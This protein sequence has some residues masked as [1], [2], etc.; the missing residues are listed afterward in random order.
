MLFLLGGVRVGQTVPPLLLDTLVSA[1]A[2]FEWTRFDP[3][4]RGN[5]AK[6]RVVADTQGS[7]G[8]KCMHGA[9]WIVCP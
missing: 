9:A 7:S 1:D 2:A 3:S 4:R 8:M 6:P 5:L